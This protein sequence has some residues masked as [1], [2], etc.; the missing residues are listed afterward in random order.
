MSYSN[1]LSCSGLM[2]RLL[3]SSWTVLILLPDREQ[4]PKSFH[5]ALTPLVD[6]HFALQGTQ[7]TRLPCYYHVYPNLFLASSHN[8]QGSF[9]HLESV[10]ASVCPP[11]RAWFLLLS[12]GQQNWAD[13][14]EKAS[15]R[16]QASNV[17]WP[18][19]GGQG[20]ARSQQEA[21]A[22]AAPTVLPASPCTL[23][24]KAQAGSRCGSLLFH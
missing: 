17:V 18:R 11:C 4:S 12:Q 10:G 1:G 7:Y 3:F 13:A 21:W 16:H 14:L 2:Q 8:F 22:R 24:F 6:C 5:E 20:K 9:K 19:A 23:R 15:C